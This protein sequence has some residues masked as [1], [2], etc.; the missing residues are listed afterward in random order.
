MK[1][2]NARRLDLARWHIREAYLCAALNQDDDAD[3]HA[4]AAREYV[5]RLVGYSLAGKS[6]DELSTLAVVTGDN[7]G[8]VS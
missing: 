7:L 2:D 8:V 1:T 4:D 6:L 3:Y 5:E